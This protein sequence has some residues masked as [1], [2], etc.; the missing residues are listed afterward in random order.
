MVNWLKYAIAFVSA[1]ALMLAFRTLAFSIHGVI[2]DGLTPL[3]QNGDRLLINRCSYGLRIDGNGL[4]PYSRL[5]RQPVE[6]GDIVVF[7]IPGG[8]LDSHDEA[9]SLGL[10]I[11]R[12]TAVPG[13]TIRTVNGL[14]TVPGLVNCAKADHYWLEAINKQ[15][16]IDSRHLGFIPEHNIIG[17]V[18]SVLYNRNNSLLP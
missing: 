16:P 2:G 11:A 13:D 17:R 15:N 7:T 3:Y 4:L 5:M 8:M 6:R 14:M 10:M 12:C 9:S 1:F 18:M